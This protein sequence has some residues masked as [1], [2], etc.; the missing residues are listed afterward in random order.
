MKYETKRFSLEIPENLKDIVGIEENEDD[1]IV[2]LLWEEDTEHDGIIVTL[3]AV[4]DKDSITSD[5]IEEIGMLTSDSGETYYLIA[6]YGEEG[7][8]SEENE[9]LYFRLVDKMFNVYESIE[10]VQGYSW[11]SMISK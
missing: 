7:A 1:V 3:K 10:P 4:K 5:N 9:E 6:V 11:K 2:K 8:C